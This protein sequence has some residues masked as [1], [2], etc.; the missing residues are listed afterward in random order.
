MALLVHCSLTGLVKAIMAA[1]SSGKG[2]RVRQYVANLVMKKR[3]EVLDNFEGN[4]PLL[5]MVKIGG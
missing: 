4:E 1:Y 2:V 3:L 5:V